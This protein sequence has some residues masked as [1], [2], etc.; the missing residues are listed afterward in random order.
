MNR[1]I[2]QD[3][4]R[5]SLKNLSSERCK[6]P[7]EL[8]KAARSRHALTYSQQACST[9]S[10]SH[11]LASKGDERCWLRNATKRLSMW[12]SKIRR[13]LVPSFLGSL[14][15]KSTLNAA[16]SRLGARLVPTNFRTTIDCILAR[17]HLPTKYNLKLPKPHAYG[18]IFFNFD[19]DLMNSTRPCKMSEIQALKSKQD[20][21]DDS[22]V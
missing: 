5:R 6:F 20:W 11:M 10:M 18:N 14:V 2:S 19:K 16:L 21:D 4:G 9:T 17:M 12:A 3:Q 1:C 22:S 15:S 13:S 7:R 8:K